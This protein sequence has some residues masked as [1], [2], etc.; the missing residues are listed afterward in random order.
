[1]SLQYE[2]DFGFSALEKQREQGQSDFPFSS[3]KQKLKLPCDDGL[4]IAGGRKQSYH[5]GQSEAREVCQPNLGLCPHLA[6]WL[7]NARC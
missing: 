7:Q 6:D 2:G 5:Q 1:M 3:W 4:P